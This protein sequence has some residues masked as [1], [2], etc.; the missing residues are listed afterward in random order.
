MKIYGDRNVKN[1]VDFLQAFYPSTNILHEGL[2]SLFQIHTP[3]RLLILT[4]HPEDKDNPINLSIISPDSSVY[5]TLQKED[6][7]I[8]LN[9]HPHQHDFYE[10]IFTTE[11]E[12]HQSLEERAMT[13]KK[14][15]VCFLNKTI[16][17]YINL[18][19]DMGFQ[20]VLLQLHPWLLNNLYQNLS[21]KMFKQEQTQMVSPLEHFLEDCTHP[22]TSLNK[23]Y[24]NL[25]PSFETSNIS[26]Y[27]FELLNDL[28]NETFSPKVGASHTI[29]KL[30]SELL[31]VLSSTIYYHGTPSIIDQTDSDLLFQRITEILEK[32]HGRA[33]RKDLEQALHYSGS[34]LNSIT[35]KYTGLTISHYAMTFC[36][37]E[38]VRLLVRT[39]QTIA[40]IAVNLGFT[41]RTH[42]YH[43][44]SNLY[45]LTPAEFRKAYQF[46]NNQDL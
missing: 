29:R 41:N 16:R 21:M 38:A 10:F 23:C 39:D 7:G 2:P 19:T 3:Y 17:H 37:K 46:T 15:D 11:G 18:N 34:Y 30:L 20:I 9:S 27:V 22:Q 45:G 5:I 33:T 13:H 43:V 1:K 14:G 4:H 28:A 42:F 32:S 25:V 40:T 8:Y 26:D 44:F 6:L 35:K 36:M 31:E 24:L 12:F